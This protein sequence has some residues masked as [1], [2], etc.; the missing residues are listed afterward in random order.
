MKQQIKSVV[1]WCGVLATGSLLNAAVTS[2]DKGPATGQPTSPPTPTLS[3][4]DKAEQTKAFEAFSVPLF[5]CISADDLKAT[6]PQ[7]LKDHNQDSKF[8]DQIFNLLQPICC[9]IPTVECIISSLDSIITLKV[10]TQDQLIALLKDN[11]QYMPQ[12]KQVAKQ[13]NKIAVFRV[14]QGLETATPSRSMTGKSY[15]RTPQSRQTGSRC[16]T[17]VHNDP[18]RSASP[19]IVVE[20]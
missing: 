3:I 4:Q 13:Q 12:A 20:A 2:P 15:A 11:L 16:S 1:L 6:I 7:Y 5:D 19:V 18:V 17:P 14:L 8:A 9:K 10:F